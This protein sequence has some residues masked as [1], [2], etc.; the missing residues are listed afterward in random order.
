MLGS[1]SLLLVDTRPFSD[2]SDSHIPGAVNVDLMQ[3]HWIDT[4]KRGIIQFNN[5][6]KI[7]LS[8]IGVS[9]NKFVV[10]YDDVSGSSAA[11]GVWLSLYFSHEKVAML[12]GGLEKWRAEGYNTETKT[13]AFVH[14]SFNG[15]PDSK[16]LADFA[17]IKLAVKKKRVVILDV[18]SKSE[19]NGSVVRAARA[20]HIPAATNIDWKG[21]LALETFKDSKKLNQIYRNIPKDAEVITYCQGGYRAANSFVVLKMLGYKN[22][23]MYLGSWGEWGNRPD[24][25]VEISRR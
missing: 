4:S 24:L 6:A 15:K 17:G 21:N 2:Y 25:P 19:Y 7:L 11:R 22:V 9:K 13:N 12:D 20:G 16:I 23:R 14:S 5:Q 10:F 1:Q 3:F 18:R 8:N